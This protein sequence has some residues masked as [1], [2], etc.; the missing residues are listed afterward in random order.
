MD[1][2]RFGKTLAGNR[3]NV[4][5]FSRDRPIVAQIWTKL[6]PNSVKLWRCWQSVAQF[7]P[8]WVKI[9][10]NLCSAGLDLDP[11]SREQEHWCAEAPDVSAETLSSGPHIARDNPQGREPYVV[12]FWP[13]GYQVVRT[14]LVRPKACR[15][16]SFRTRL[17]LHSALLSCSSSSYICVAQPSAVSPCTWSVMSSTYSRGRPPW[18]LALQRPYERFE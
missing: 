5:A 16:P 2:E 1:S 7:R 17:S 9:R 13:F 3:P 18:A 15:L 8:T 6:S 4:G 14:S 11:S 12:E 10:P